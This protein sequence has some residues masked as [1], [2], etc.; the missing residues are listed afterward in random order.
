MVIA[1]MSSPDESSS[2]SNDPAPHQQGEAAV[3][4]HS[5]VNAPKAS[6]ET[7][8]P[9][10][11]PAPAPKPVAL[12]LPI[13][14]PARRP[15]G[16]T[17]ALPRRRLS[18]PDKA[19]ALADASDEARR[20]I[21]RIVSVT[22]TPWGG[23]VS[24]SSDQVAKMEKALRDLEA[25]LAEREHLVMELEGKLAEKERDLAE[26][27]ALIHARERV[28]EAA[29]HSASL[30]ASP[31]APISDAERAALEALRDELDR[32][33]KSIAEQRAVIA[34]RERFLDDNETKLFEKMQAQQ[35][36]ETELDQKAEV[37]AAKEARLNAK[38]GEAPAA[39]TPAKKWDE[40]NQ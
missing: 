35:E 16:P 20:S 9:P 1:I 11:A 17:L 38:S 39:Q 21:D 18:D 36:L 7:T 25:K 37:L 29:K 23:P 22:K 32:R 27:E 26:A 28:L 5:V 3:T 15:D 40:F 30:S 10:A 8:L 4:S 6:G 34:E 19:Q 33:E 13:R 24:L 12:K 31:D 14:F 2:P